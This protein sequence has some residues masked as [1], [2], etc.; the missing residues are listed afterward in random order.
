MIETMIASSSFD[1]SLLPYQRIEGMKEEDLASYLMDEDKKLILLAL[2]KKV[3]AFVALSIS[4]D[5]AEI[6]YLAI[7]KEEEGKGY[8]NQ[9]LHNAFELLKKEYQTKTVFLEVREH[10]IRATSLYEKNGF[11]LYRKRKNYYLSPVED[12][13]CYRK[14]LVP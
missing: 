8:S 6:D 5:E 9:L 1:L 3:I 13:L 2:D 10:N 4:L 7:R 12:A 11:I 14:E